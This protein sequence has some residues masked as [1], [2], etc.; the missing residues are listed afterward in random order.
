MNG[1]TRLLGAEDTE[2]CKQK[3]RGRQRSSRCSKEAGRDVPTHLLFPLLP[4]FLQ[5]HLPVLEGKPTL[6]SDGT[7]H[8]LKAVLREEE[9]LKGMEPDKCELVCTFSHIT[10]P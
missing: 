6:F 1:K 7:A 10:P 9:I 4:K 8:L 5:P 2:V 3:G